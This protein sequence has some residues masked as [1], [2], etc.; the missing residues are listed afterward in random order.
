LLELKKE[1][2]LSYLFVSHD[3]AVI[4]HI[5][6]RVAVMFKGKIVEEGDCADIVNNPQNEYTK[7]LLEAVPRL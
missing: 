2:G 6:D 3:L 7:T 1:F 4:N 5:A